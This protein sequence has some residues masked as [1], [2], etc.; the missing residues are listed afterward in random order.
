MRRGGAGLGRRAKRDHRAAGDQARPVAVMG[1]LDRVGDRVGV[2][3]VDPLG[4]PAMRAE[5]LDLVVG[6]R[7]AGRPVD[8]DRVVVVKHDQLVEAQM[9]GDR[10]RLVADPLHQAAIAAKDVGVVIDDVAAE[11]RR[12]HALGERHADRIA[13]PLAER[14]GR[15]LDAGRVTALGMA[16]G[17]AAELPEMLDLVDRHVGIAGQV[18]QPVEQHRAVPVRQHKAVAVGPVRG[19]R[20]KPQ[21]LGE[22]H[23]GDVGHAHRH[24]GMTRFRLF[25]RVHRERTQ[26]I[27]HMAQFRVP[28]RGERS[29]GG[30]SAGHPGKIVTA[31]ARAKLSTPGQ[32][33]HGRL[34]ALQDLLM[35][36]ICVESRRSG[37]PTAGATGSR[38]T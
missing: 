28:R 9:P 37:S 23:R 6:H 29:R 12:Q 1:A 5:P 13:E 22:Q 30:G 11:L 25:D 24:A 21:V 15:R 33:W 31:A 7:E 26:R 36:S 34:K 8:R 16:G 18:E 20:V 38:C 19:L 3:A 35:V 17:A 2:V 14:P 27:G 4:G 32:L 10:Q